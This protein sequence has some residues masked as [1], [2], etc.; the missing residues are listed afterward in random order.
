MHYGL[1]SLMIRPSKTARTKAL[2]L[3][4]KF[5]I[6][7]TLEVL[8]SLQVDTFAWREGRSDHRENVLGSSTKKW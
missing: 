7:I 4:L 5:Q 6:A 3:H 8:K 1:S 2:S